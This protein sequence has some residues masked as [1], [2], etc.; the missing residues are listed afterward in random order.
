MKAA[1]ESLCDKVAQ[2]TEQL[3]LL[4]TTTL[5]GLTAWFDAAITVPTV[6]GWYNVRYKMSEEERES[7]QP[8]LQRRWWNVESNSFGWPVIVG[9]AV[10][11]EDLVRCQLR[12][13][14]APTIAF[15]WQG[16]SW[17]HP[18]MPRRMTSLS[19]QQI[20]EVAAALVLKRIREEDKK[21]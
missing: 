9:D 13:S 20:E 12:I 14:T 19:R 17:K 10:S 2:T 3:E 11:D 18:D 21:E 16:L 8:G 6:S 7:R 1:L 5:I 15:E 4:G